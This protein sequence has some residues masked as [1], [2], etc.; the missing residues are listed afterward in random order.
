LLISFVLLVTTYMCSV[1]SNGISQR[2]I[3]LDTW[4]TPLAHT[5]TYIH[6]PFIYIIHIHRVVSAKMIVSL[7]RLCSYCGLFKI[8]QY[9]FVCLISATTLTSTGKCLILTH[10][11]I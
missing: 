7:K 10:C 5:Y 11:H 9:I 4:C 1:L 2:M 3:E 8:L 6:I